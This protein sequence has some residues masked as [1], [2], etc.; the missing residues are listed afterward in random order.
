MTGE[1]VGDIECKRTGF[2][3]FER[4]G[5]Q[6]DSRNAGCYTEIHSDKTVG[7]RYQNVRAGLQLHAIV[8]FDG[9]Q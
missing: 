8:A 7:G 2:E 3:V 4:C 9:S 6:K 5:Y 1:F